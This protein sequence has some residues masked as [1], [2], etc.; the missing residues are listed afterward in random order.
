MDF[1]SKSFGFFLS[2]GAMGFYL[3]FLLIFFIIDSYT[4]P[5]ILARL[6]ARVKRLE[7]KGFKQKEAK[8]LTVYRDEKGKIVFIRHDKKKDHTGEKAAS[9]ADED[10]K[11]GD[12]KDDVEVE[13]VVELKKGAL[14][15]DY[16]GK[17]GKKY[18]D[19]ENVAEAFLT[20]GKNGKSGK[21]GDK[22]D[23]KLL[24]Q[25]TGKKFKENEDNMAEEVG[26]KKSKKN[27]P[28]DDSKKKKKDEGE[29]L[30]YYNEYG[31]WIEANE[32]ADAEN[33]YGEEEEQEE[34]EEDLDAI[35]A[36]KRAK[37]DL[38]E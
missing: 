30:G 6:I 18:A 32:D 36:Q 24:G 7:L 5:K 13:Q 31:E 12:K 25:S 2:L 15:G 10:K 28:G 21:K 34:P 11:G 22:T 27:G 37:D 16:E 29:E 1:W 26:D 35:E 14:N 17:S 3:V 20:P 33:N 38:I 23:S 9:Q 19:E 8:K 4:V